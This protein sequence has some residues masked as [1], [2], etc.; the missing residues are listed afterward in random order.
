LIG[1]TGDAKE[2]RK[3]AR[4]YKVYAAKT[5]PSRRDDPNF[6]YSGLV[7]LVDAAGKYVG[8]SRPAPRPAC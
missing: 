8:T 7:Y 2:I 1:L 5:V 6:D 4:A 3:V